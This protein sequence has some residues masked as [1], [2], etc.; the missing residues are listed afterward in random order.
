MQ[1]E[2]LSSINTATNADQ[3]AGQGAPYS[4]LM[5]ECKLVPLF[6][7]SIWRLL[8]NLKTEPYC[9]AIPLLSTYPKGST[10]YYTLTHLCSLLLYS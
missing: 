9:S 5:G 6:W 7:K 8:K 4:L 3:D 2:W 1:S 10:S